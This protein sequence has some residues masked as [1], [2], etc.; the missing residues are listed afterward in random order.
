MSLVLHGGYGKSLFVSHNAIR[1]AP[2]HVAERQDTGIP[3]RNIAAFQTGKV[4]L[5]GLQQP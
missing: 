2:E 4:H 1:I 5:L 3:I